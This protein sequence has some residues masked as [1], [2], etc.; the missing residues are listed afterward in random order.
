MNIKLLT[1]LEK[2]LNF[3]MIEECQ[4]VFQFCSSN[5]RGARTALQYCMDSILQV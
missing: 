2:T 5:T 4:L 3:I 1:A